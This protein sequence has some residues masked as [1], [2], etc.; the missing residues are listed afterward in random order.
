MESQFSESSYPLTF[1]ESDSRVLGEHLRLRHSVELV[2][3]KHVG[4]SNFLRFFLFHKDI[5]KTYI[6]EFEKHMFIPVDLNDLVEKE[7][8]AFW[9]LTFKRLVDTVEVSETMSNADKGLIASMFL[10][11][12]QS[13]N[14]FLTIENLRESIKIIIKN[15]IFPTIFFIRFDRI[16]DAVSEE[17]LANLQGLSDATAQK[18]SYVFTSFRPL[19]DLSPEVFSR[20][21]LSVFSHLMYIKGAKDADMK[22]IFES[23]EKKYNLAPSREVLS[24]IIET[25]AGHVQ[26]LQISLIVL[27]NL[28]TAGKKTDPKSLFSTIVR[29]ERVGLISEEIWDSLQEEEKYIVKKIYNGESPFAEEEEAGSYL[30]ETGLVLRDG[31]NL[32]IFSPYFEFFIRRL[33]KKGEDDA[34]DFSKKENMLFNLLLENLGEICEREV[35]IETVWPEYDDLGVSDWTIDQLVARLRSK[36]KKQG[37]QYL[38]K[39][40][41]TRGYRMVEES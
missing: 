27:N 10:N 40:V 11:S 2:G 1:R 38:I 41:R 21:S 15:G 12:I 6:S 18:L 33:I 28:L 13:R 16:K 39:T 34:V 22:V 32:K 25:C 4:I 3:I 17:F 30:W 23:L 26:Y 9:V 7:I 19:D 5:V 24:R 36:L 20:K 37:S 35:I 8:F 14:F 29:D 31:E